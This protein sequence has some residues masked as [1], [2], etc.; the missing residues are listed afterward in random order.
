[1]DGDRPLNSL[2]AGLHRAGSV[3]RA[4][5]HPRALDIDEA[6]GSG[7][8]LVCWEDPGGA[9]ALHR[10]LKPR[11]E[12]A[13][14]AGLCRSPQ[15]LKESP[16]RPAWLRLACFEPVED[17]EAAV[18][19][20]GL[21]R[22]EVGPSW[23]HT[24]A[25]V[26]GEASKSDREV[27]DEPAEAF[28]VAIEMPEGKRGVELARL[29]A[30]LEAEG[31]DRVWGAPPGAS[32]M[33]LRQAAQQELGLGIEPTLDALLE[34]EALFAQDRLGVVRYIPPLVFQ[35]LCDMIA[36]IANEELGRPVQWAETHPDEQGLRA[37]P[38][39]RA[40]L[41]DGVVYIPLGQHVL[42]WCMMPLL[43]GESVPPLA[44][45]ALDQFARR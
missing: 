2:I 26:R 36:V 30:A 15:E 31:I 20:F 6:T 44:D 5:V 35:G 13:L 16:R 17:V 11:V 9:A 42:R 14:L 3:P 38:V 40:K 21:A 37:P 29:E 32:F 39:V 24:L 27:P 10:A 22:A 12:A 8:V 19:A 7:L 28:E 34:V 43:P 18:R 45:W 1:M 25:H 41:D 23:R 33:R 4:P